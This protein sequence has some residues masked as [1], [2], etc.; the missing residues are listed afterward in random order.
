[1]YEPWE[2]HLRIKDITKG[3][4][5]FKQKSCDG[6][7]NNCGLNASTEPTG[8]KTAPSKHGHYI[9]THDD[10]NILEDRVIGTSDY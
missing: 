4:C 10:L 9:C 8:G 7:C 5:P 2:N 1:M 3:R 6:L